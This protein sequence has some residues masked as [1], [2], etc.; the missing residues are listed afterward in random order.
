MKI[1]IWPDPCLKKVSE[2]VMEPLNQEYIWAL[3]QTMRNDG[4]IG[5][6]AIQ[7]GLAQ[8][9]F[10]IDIGEGC[11]TYVNPIIK[12]YMGKPGFVN[13]GCL[14]IPGQFESIKR[15]PEVEVAYWLQDLSKE[16]TEILTGLEAHV[17]QHEYEHLEGNLFIDKLPPGKRDLIRSNLKKLKLQGRGNND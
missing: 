2:P 10:I 15:F 12:T 3:H 7:V 8:R 11:K 17:F 9:F 6:S 14:S 13:E 4:G 16:V 1:L 5:L